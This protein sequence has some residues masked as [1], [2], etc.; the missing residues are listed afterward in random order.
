MIRRVVHQVRIHRVVGELDALRFSGAGYP[1]RRSSAL[2]HGRGAADLVTLFDDQ[3]VLHA[4]VL[5]FDRARHA[6]AAAAAHQ[7]VDLSIPSTSEPVGLSP[8]ERSPQARPMRAPQPPSAAPPMKLRREIPSFMTSLLLLQPNRRSCGH[9][10]LPGDRSVSIAILV[11]GALPALL[12]DP[13]SI[14]RRTG[15]THLPFW[16]ESDLTLP[17]LLNC[18]QQGFWHEQGVGRETIL[19][20][21][22]RRFGRRVSRG[23]VGRWMF[24][25]ST[26]AVCSS[27]AARLD[28]PV[29]S[30]PVVPISPTAMLTSE[31]TTVLIAG[32]DFSIASA[33]S[34]SSR[35]AVIVALTSAWSAA[36]A[37]HASDRA[38]LVLAPPRCCRTA[39]LSRPSIQQSR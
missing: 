25:A 23:G 35:E 9:N 22:E 1:N 6:G 17:I 38:S 26:S 8:Q 11:V 4:I 37:I 31:T 21:N 12:D 5:G 33:A 27:R 13:L 29:Q 10:A 24:R 2:G 28:S 15:A 39:A 7:Q 16:V 3:H 14:G 18:L 34:S 19:S 30:R 20:D 32:L 36:Q